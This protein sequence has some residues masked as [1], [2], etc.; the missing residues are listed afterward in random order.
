MPGQQPPDARE[1]GLYLTLAQVG[2]EMVAPMIVGLAIDHYA[3]TGPWLTVAGLIL[4]FVGGLAH[5]VLL[6]KK[7][8]AARREKD[9]RGNGAA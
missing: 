7:Q 2:V 9:K 6:T 4:G 3:N 1:M 8:D 5:I